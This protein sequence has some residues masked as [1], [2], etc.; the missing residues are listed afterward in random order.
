MER[1]QLGKRSEDLAVT[2]LRKAGLK[3]VQRNYRCKLGEIDCVARDGNSIVFV[4]V[5]SRSTADS[6]S[7]KYSIGPKK[8]QTLSKVA[9]Y[10]L[11]RNGLLSN[12]A[13]FDVVTVVFEGDSPTIEWTRNAFDCAMG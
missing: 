2:Y 13:R 5:R 7:P 10:Y 12:S 8:I 11:K 3:I 6:G 1:T 9:L 4:E